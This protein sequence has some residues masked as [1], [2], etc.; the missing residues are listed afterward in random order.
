[1]Y[2]PVLDP[3]PLLTPSPATANNQQKNE[4]NFYESGI[5]VMRQ[6]DS[7]R[8]ARGTGFF[9]NLNFIVSG[10]AKVQ[11]GGSEDKS[12]DMILFFHLLRFQGRKLRLAGFKDKSFY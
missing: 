11:G 12:V 5:Q 9:F 7:I 2:Q 10:S 1:M 6:Q 3:G 4:D 8:K